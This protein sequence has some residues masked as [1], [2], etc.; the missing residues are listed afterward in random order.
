[1]DPKTYQLIV[2]RKALELYKNTGMKANRAY[3]PLA[4]MKTAARLTGRTFLKYD[5]DGAIKALSEV[6]GDRDGL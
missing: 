5:Y 3:T 1:M 6:L 4:M 2:L